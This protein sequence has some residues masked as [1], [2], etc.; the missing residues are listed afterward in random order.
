MKKYHL[1]TGSFFLTLLLWLFT[2]AVY[3]QAHEEYYTISGVV[4]D[5]KSKK[6]L[7]NVNISLTGYNTGTVTNKEGVFS[8]K[9]LP[10]QNS[11]TIELSH[12]GYI[13]GQI[14]ID[15]EDPSDIECYLIPNSIILDAITVSPVHAC[16]IVIQAMDKIEQSYPDFPIMLTGFYRETVQKGKKYISVSEAVTDVFKTTHKEDTSRERTRISKGR[17]LLSPKARDTLAVKLVG[18]PTQATALDIVKNPYPL[19]DPE[20]VDWYTY[21]F[22][23]YITIGDRLHYVIT[24]RP[25]VSVPF[26]LYEG[27]YYIDRESLSFSRMEFNT[28]MRDRRKVTEQILRKKPAGLEF[29][30]QSV[31]YLITYRTIEGKSQ[32]N[33]IFNEIK[34]QCD[35][36]K[37][38]FRTNYTVTS[39]M[40]IT[41][42]YA[43]PTEI[44]PYKDSF[45]SHY[46]LSDKI[47][48]FYD[49]NF[50]GAYNIIEP[51]ESLEN[52][53]RKLKK[54]QWH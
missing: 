5:Q 30:P 29:K 39:E 46:I 24:F 28:E 45:R 51:T 9:I 37:K 4:K 19:L 20:T 16:E 3:S 15:R 8:L 34:F 48:N 7:E 12:L 26:P 40:V 18:G 25:R 2:S 17:Q 50:W 49:E 38:W 43:Y 52:A 14:E 42:R 41:D 36:K 27:S 6:V 23:E 35:W 54:M 22:T 13:S 44:I 11:R 10:G 33:Y 31:T 32:L 1:F 21:E 53:V 47:N